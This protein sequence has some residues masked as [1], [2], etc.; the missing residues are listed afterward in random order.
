MYFRIVPVAGCSLPCVFE[1]DFNALSGDATGWVLVKFDKF[2]HTD[3]T[4]NVSKAFL[5]RVEAAK[6]LG[7]EVSVLFEEVHHRFAREF[8]KYKYRNMGWLFTK[9]A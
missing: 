8:H 6:V 4:L 5:L 7:L 3:S 1:V 9:K 2:R